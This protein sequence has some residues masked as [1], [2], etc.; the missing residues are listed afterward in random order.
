MSSL[1]SQA[2]FELEPQSVAALVGE[3]LDAGHDPLDVLAECRQ[4]M[5]IVGDRF[6]SGE[7]FLSELLLSAEIFKDA[8]RILEPHLARSRSP[9]PMGAVVLAT[10]KGD[11][12]DM[13]KNILATLLR[14]HGFVVHDLG[15]DV[16]PAV[17][18]DKVR[19]I[20]PELV[21]FSA[22]ITTVFERMREA[23]S[24]LEQAGLRE[25]VKLMIGG[26]VTTPALKQFVGAD[27]QSTEAT[28]AVAYCLD[29]VGAQADHAR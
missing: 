7:Y 19:E 13:G 20:R 5:A 4:G 14:A 12:H 2:I 26:G 16:P 17:V 29:V 24:L 22:L 23:A 8:M 6:Q 25:G 15:V 27:F 11:I 28:V 18:V 1:L 10:L 9:E 21:G 3:R